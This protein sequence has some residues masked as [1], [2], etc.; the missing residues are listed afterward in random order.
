MATDYQTETEPP[1]STLISGIV[2]DARQLFVEQLTLFQ[3]EIKNDIRRMVMAVVPLIIGAVVGFA[4]VLILLMGVAFFINWAV[5]DMPTWGG[6]AAVGG[7]IV[8]VSIGLIFWGKAK[9]S[10]ISPLPDT[11][12]EG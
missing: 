4:G 7:F 11:A 6:F 9:L 8:L 1:V 10:A 2:Q 12:L 5:P 3:V